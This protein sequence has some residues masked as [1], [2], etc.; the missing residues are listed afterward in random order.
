MLRFLKPVLTLV[1][2]AVLAL[3]PAAAAI[4]ICGDNICQGTGLPPETCQTCPA[5]CGAC[6]GD[7]DGDG[8]RDSEDNCPNHANADQK[9]CDQDGVGDVCDSQNGPYWV[10][11][12]GPV[13][14]YTNGYPGS[15]GTSWTWA[16][17]EKK[18]RD[19]C[20]L[21][22]DQWLFYNSSSNFCSYESYP[23]NCCLIWHGSACY[24]TFRN[25]TCRY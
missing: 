6:P 16:N 15:P 8:I 18:F 14:C 5:D 13:I 22:P 3:P 9:D 23:F 4:P 11:I 12:S 1:A 21:Q 10:A 7:A 25:N 17:R 24:S 20:G 19:A 2:F